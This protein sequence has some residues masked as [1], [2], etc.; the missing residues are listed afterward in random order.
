LLGTIVPAFFLSSRKFREDK[1][2][3]YF[4]SLFIISGFL[5]NRINVSVT[6]LSAMT[7]TSYFP[8]VNEISVTLML[9]VIGMW[10]FKLII[11]NF[12]VFSEELEIEKPVGVFESISKPLTLK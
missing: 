9:V 6:S 3:L 12:P 7:S 1:K 8:S 10:A 2:Y 4:S 5:L 11:E